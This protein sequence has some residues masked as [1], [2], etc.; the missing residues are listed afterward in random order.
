MLSKSR[1][2]ST[3]KRIFFMTLAMGLA[4][5]SAANIVIFWMARVIDALTQEDS[6]VLVYS[7][8]MNRQE[9]I[10]AL[11]R[12]YGNWGAAYD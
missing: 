11:A 6:K 12:D 10:A 4:V 8:L 7:S 5:F 1:I 3:P 2:E 9:R